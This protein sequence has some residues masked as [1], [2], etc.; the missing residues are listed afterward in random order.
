MWK[1]GDAEFIPVV[2]GLLPSSRIQNVLLGSKTKG[3]DRNPHSWDQN[4]DFHISNPLREIENHKN[5]IEHQKNGIEHQKNG[6]QNALNDI[7][8]STRLTEFH[9]SLQ[10]QRLM[11]HAADSQRINSN[12]CAQNS[13]QQFAVSQ[14]QQ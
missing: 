1:G 5:G 11:K 14:Q 7:Q 8:N 9:T 10:K 2:P 3:R 13:P 12:V 6:I 4:P